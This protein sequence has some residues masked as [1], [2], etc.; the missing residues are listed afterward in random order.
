[1]RVAS[2]TR[3]SFI[4][5]VARASIVAALGLLLASA[6]AQAQDLNEDSAAAM[7]AAFMADIEVMR[8][9]FLGLAEAFPAE[10]YT[11]RP[12][13]GVRSVSE[14]L[15]LIASEGYGFVPMAVG[16]P[17]ALSR[18]ESQGLPAITDKAEVIDHLTRGFDYAREQLEALDPATHDQRPQPVR[19]GA[20]DP[21]DHVLRG[22]GHAR[23]PRA[24]HRVRTDQPHRAA[25]EPVR[26][27]ETPAAARPRMGPERP[28]ARPRGAARESVAKT[29][30]AT[31]PSTAKTNL[32]A[33]GSVQGGENPCCNETV[34]GSR[35]FRDGLL[36][37]RQPRR[38]R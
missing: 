25:L 38:G 3:R 27:T 28:P 20:D 32:V 33:S 37:S 23:A 29:R 8:E 7:K 19:A 22:R 12:M 11:W 4:E 5:R 18:E 6:P 30:A 10:T 2:P 34:D 14:V 13:E 36:D 24:A 1:M 9:K 15:M 31:R 35:G 17:T 16:A 26:S 21:G